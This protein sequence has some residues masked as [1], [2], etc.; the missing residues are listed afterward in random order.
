[1]IVLCYGRLVH[2]KDIQK[3]TRHEVLALLD[4]A[5]IP[6]EALPMHDER[7]LR[8]TL[9][10]VMLSMLHH[11]GQRELTVLADRIGWRCHS[12]N[13]TTNNTNNTNTTNVDVLR[14][15]LR[16]WIQQP[17]CTLFRQD[18]PFRGTITAHHLHNVPNLARSI[19][20]YHEEQLRTFSAEQLQ[21]LLRQ[22]YQQD[23]GTHTQLLQ[24]LVAFQEFVMYEVFQTKDARQYLR[25]HYWISK[26]DRL[27]LPDLRRLCLIQLR[28]PYLSRSIPHYDKVLPSEL[29]RSE[30]AMAS[31]RRRPDYPQE[32]MVH[33]QRAYEEAQLIRKRAMDARADLVAGGPDP[34]AATTVTTATTSLHGA[35][36]NDDALSHRDRSIDDQVSHILARDMLREHLRPDV[37]VSSE[38]VVKSVP[39]FL[40]YRPVILWNW[41]REIMYRSATFDFWKL[42]STVARIRY[43]VMRKPESARNL[44]VL[45]LTGGDQW[46]NATTTATTYSIPSSGGTPHQRQPPDQRQPSDQRRPSDM[47]GDR[48]L[49][50]HPML[51][52][53]EMETMSITELKEALTARG[54][55]ASG[56]DHRQLLQRLVIFQEYAITRACNPEDLSNFLKQSLC[57][58][59]PPISE[60]M[61]A[62]L[63]RL[64]SHCIAALR[65]P[66]ADHQLATPRF[67][68]SMV[69]GR[70][71]LRGH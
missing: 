64:R 71:G 6:E 63:A 46:R 58:I 41:E 36:G 67:V 33:L 47:D 57:R 38:A 39:I 11:M 61:L 20:F 14:E 37:R 10:N 44:L 31:I 70:G 52:F 27:Y 5:R 55:D 32:E 9:R 60:N 4:T 12:T 23:H 43:G 26:M 30:E 8:V 49:R 59:P 24:R 68:F 35:Y 62:T 50:R 13:N 48:L 54:V 29:H 66:L 45:Q 15:M 42:V 22:Q 51:S 28:H 53:Y 2:W 19:H 34:V 25:D 16:V 17:D 3:L 56:T 65:Y 21:T 69:E 7:K 40:R 18:Q 1:M